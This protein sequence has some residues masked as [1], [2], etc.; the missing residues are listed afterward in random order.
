MSVQRP[1]RCGMHDCAPDPRSPRYN[2]LLFFGV[3]VGRATEVKQLMT[4]ANC[5]LVLE[6]GRSSSTMVT[7]ST[8]TSTMVVVLCTL[9][10]TAYSTA[11]STRSRPAV[12]T[13]RLANGV[14]MPILTL[15]TPNCPFTE[16]D[17][18]RADV[19]LEVTLLISTC[20]TARSLVSL[21]QSQDVR[22][23]CFLP[24]VIRQ[25]AK[26]AHVL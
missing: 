23:L 9:T 24:V 2:L 25:K 11:P 13:V 12:P 1:H 8:N 7:R 17:G 20:R 6:I 19:A 21:E 26:T 15:G 16:P 4:C 18:C 22:G 5:E 14:N 10:A 3:T